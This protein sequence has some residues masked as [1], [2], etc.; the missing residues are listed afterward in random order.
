MPAYFLLLLAIIIQLIAAFLA[1][2]LV[3]ITRRTTAWLFISIGF[4][5]MAIRRCFT[6]SEWFARGMS[7][8]PVDIG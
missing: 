1:F 3:R 2:R 7:L 6:L 4:L 8:M 5:L